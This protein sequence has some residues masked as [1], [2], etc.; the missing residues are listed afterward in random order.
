[1]FYKYFVPNGT[2][3]RC[4]SKFTLTWNPFGDEMFIEIHKKKYNKT[5]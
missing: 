1:M 4:C 3:K 5:L 2:K